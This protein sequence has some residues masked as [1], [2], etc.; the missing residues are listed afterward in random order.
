MVLSMKEQERKGGR[1]ERRG[2]G[3]RERERER[4]ILRQEFPQIFLRVC[5]VTVAA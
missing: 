4:D 5:R 3:E 2:G 1:G